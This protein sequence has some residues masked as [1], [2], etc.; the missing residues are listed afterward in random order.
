MI[1]VS[2]WLGGLG[3]N[4]LLEQEGRLKIT[5][6]REDLGRFHMTYEQLD[7]A[8]EP[9]RHMMETLLKSA[10]GITGFDGGD[11]RLLIEVFPAPEEGCVIY[12][13][14]LAGEET[15]PPQRFRL[16]HASR[17]Q[18]TV[19]H[20]ADS[21]SLL[22]AIG[23]L[24]G[25]G[26]RPSDSSLYALAGDYRLVLYPKEEQQHSIRL[27]LQEYGKELPGNRAAM[28]YLREHGRLLCG[29]NAVEEI[30]RY[31]S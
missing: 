22:D 4:I 2:N 8:N 9:T 28:A 20:F 12:F 29:S 16:R 1:V 18:P 7:Y 11:G 26:S 24:H 23:R 13:T 31:L 3:M 25:S 15:Q 21:G 19:F 17:A 5:L 27:L 10:G 6:N 30:G 14:R